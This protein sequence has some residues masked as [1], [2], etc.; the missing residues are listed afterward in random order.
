MDHLILIA[1]SIE[2][3]SAP[4]AAETEPDLFDV[5]LEDT[6]ESAKN[7]REARKSQRGGSRGGDGNTKR[8]KKDEKFGFGGKKRF[9]KSGDAKSS[10]DMR[11]YSVS[12]MKGK[13]GGRGGAASRPGKARR[14]AGRP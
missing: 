5:E 12:K 3:G 13:T 11:D 1:F 14:A 4:I 2:R 9:G 6:A 8:R 7:D 10:A